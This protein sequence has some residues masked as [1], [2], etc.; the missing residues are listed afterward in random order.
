MGNG[1]LSRRGNLLWDL[2][3]VMWLLMGHL[4]GCGDQQHIMILKTSNQQQQ[5]R[6]QALTWSVYLGIESPQQLTSFQIPHLFTP[7]HSVWVWH[8][9]M[10]GGE[11]VICLEPKSFSQWLPDFVSVSGTCFSQS[12]FLFF[13]SFFLSFL[14]F[15]FL[16]AHFFLFNFLTCPSAFLEEAL[17]TELVNCV[18]GCFYSEHHFLLKL[19]TL[20][21]KRP[22]SLS[23]LS[24]MKSHI[25]SGYHHSKSGFPFFIASSYR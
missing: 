16:K 22:S 25:C 17:S 13:L 15:F 9:E 11:E 2:S 3:L 5:K 24:P 14:F 23:C 1:A 20:S 18:V 6:Q 12:L 21:F 7:N 8:R 4:P 19:N 10:E